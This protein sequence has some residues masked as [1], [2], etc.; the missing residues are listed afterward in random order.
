[1]NE[2]TEDELKDILYTLEEERVRIEESLEVI[3]NTLSSIGGILYERA[4]RY[5][6]AHIE[7]ALRENTRWLGGSFITMEDTLEEIRREVEPEDYR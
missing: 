4:H 1:M 7:G 5:W 2:K 6:I 3:K